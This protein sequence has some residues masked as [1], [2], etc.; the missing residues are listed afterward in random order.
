[1]KVDEGTGRGGIGCLGNPSAPEKVFRDPQS[2]GKGVMRWFRVPVTRQI[3]VAQAGRC[4]SDRGSAGSRG[5]EAGKRMM[6]FLGIP[7]DPP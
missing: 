4:Q 5:K 3:P 2:Q 1:M 7:L 6:E